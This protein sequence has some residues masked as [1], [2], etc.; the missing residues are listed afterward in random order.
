KLQGQ[1]FHAFQIPQKK[2]SCIPR[3]TSVRPFAQSR[4][5]LSKVFNYFS[6]VT[7]E[8]IKDF[9]ENHSNQKEIHCHFHYHF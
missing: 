3:F 7:Y 1:P 4:S 8:D 9:N 5:V 2:P 6:S